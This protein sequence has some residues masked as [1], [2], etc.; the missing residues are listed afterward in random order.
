[1]VICKSCGSERA[2]K[3]GIIRGKQRYKRRSCR[4][5][6]VEGDERTSE[7]IVALKALC[8]LFYSLG[9][10]SYG[11]LGKIVGRDRAL[12]YR[13]I[14]EAGLNTEEPIAKGDIKEMEFDEMLH[15]V[16]SK[17]NKLGS[18]K[19]LTVVHGELWPG[20]LVTVILQPSGGSIEKSNT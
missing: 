20:C 4:Y 18:S 12:I 17:K 7:P 11:M 6:F 15:F 9:K 13:W 19:L 1:M 14:R 16:G 10:S 5:F 2:V 3:S 8:V